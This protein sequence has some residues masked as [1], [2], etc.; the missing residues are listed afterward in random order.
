MPPE[1]REALD[2]SEQ[3]VTRQVTQDLHRATASLGR[4]QK[5]VREL[6][7]SRDRHK[8]KWMQYLQDSLKLWND[9]M[10]AFDAQQESF[11]QAI[12]KAKED[13]NQAHHNIQV[14]NAR[15]AGKPAP[16]QLVAPKEELGFPSDMD[17]E[18]KASRKKLHD[19]MAQ[20]A[21]KACGNPKE[22]KTEVEA[23]MDSDDERRESKRHRSAS[24]AGG[25]LAG[26][27]AAPHPKSTVPVKTSSWALVASPHVW[28]MRDV[29]QEIQAEFDSVELRPTLRSMIEWVQQAPRS[30]LMTA[31][32]IAINP[33]QCQRIG[34]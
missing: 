33:L 34:I 17:P 25:E 27:G 29:C 11:V 22:E 24:P 8:Q 23:I 9:Q 10:I 14:L 32:S 30:V 13:M 3:G 18:E 7:E 12:A 2:K 16:E 28:G 26:L 5:A 21:I 31:Y 4:A 1:V 20:C 15:A 6:M 19:L